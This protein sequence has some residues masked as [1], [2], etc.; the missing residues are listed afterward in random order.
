MRGRRSAAAFFP[1]RPPAPVHLIA[2]LQHDDD[3]RIWTTV[4]AF[5][6]DAHVAPVLLYVERHY[7]R[8]D[9]HRRS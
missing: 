7:S 4:A 6:A 9:D 3:D 1:T 8:D 5:N 2:D